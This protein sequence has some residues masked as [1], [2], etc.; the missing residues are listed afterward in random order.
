MLVG[1]I[2]NVGAARFGFML[3]SKKS[4]GLKN[5]IMTAIG[6]PKYRKP[7]EYTP[8]KVVYIRPRDALG[9]FVAYKNPKQVDV[10]YKTVAPVVQ[11][12]EV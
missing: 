8:P 11:D 10:S 2:F 6:H 4:K 12:C 1:M 5:D 7:Y 3:G 9:R